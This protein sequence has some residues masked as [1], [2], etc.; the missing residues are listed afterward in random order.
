MLANARHTAEGLRDVERRCAEL[1]A[2]VENHDA[3]ALRRLL[4]DARV[5][6]QSLDRNA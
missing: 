6:R 2:A 5:A 4:A 1:R 3:A